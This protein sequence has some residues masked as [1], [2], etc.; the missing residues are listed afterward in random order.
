MQNIDKAKQNILVSASDVTPTERW[1]NRWLQLSVWRSG[2]AR[3]RIYRLQKERKR[4]KTN[5]CSHFLLYLIHHLLFCGNVFSYSERKKP[6]CKKNTGC[7]FPLCVWTKH[8]IYPAGNLRSQLA[9]LWMRAV[10]MRIKDWGMFAGV[11]A[12]LRVS[13]PVRWC[14]L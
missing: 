11:K 2:Y 5:E 4:K 3:P 13:G 14:T 1:L 10:I 12:H 6:G 7:T 8:S 9:L